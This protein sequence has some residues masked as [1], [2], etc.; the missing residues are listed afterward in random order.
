MENE[1]FDCKRNVTNVPTEI[2]NELN[3]I[4]KAFIWNGNNPKIE[5]TA[6]YN[7]YKNCGLKNMDI[8]SKII[9]IKNSW[10]KRL[11]TLSYLIDTYLGKDFKFHSNLD[12]YLRDGGKSIFIS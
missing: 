4:Q 12:K 6:L 2:V 9:S 10:V 7:K 5:H 8:L 11:I 3:K 1:K